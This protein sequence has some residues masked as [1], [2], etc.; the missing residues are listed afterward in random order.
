MENLIRYKLSAGEASHMCRDVSDEEIKRAMFLI[1]DN[2]APG[3]Y[4]FSSLFFK[5]SW[6]IIGKDVCLVVKEF[7]NTEKILREI[8]STLIALVPKIQTPLKVFD[9]RPITCCNVLYKCISK[10]IF[11]RLKGCLDKLVSKNQSAFVPRRHIQDNIM[12]DHE[13]FK[14]YDRKVGPK[15]IALK[16]DIQKAY[17]TGGRGLRQGDP[18]SPY[19]FTLV[20]EIL[21]QMIRQKIEQC[22]E[23]KYH[24]GCKRLKITNVCFADDLLLFCHADKT[25]VEKLPIRYLGVLLTSKRIGIKECKSLLDKVECRINNWK[26]RCLSYAGRLLLVALVLESIHVYWASVFLLP[27]GVIKDI[28]KLLKG[29][30]WNH[31]D[32]SKG[33]AKVAW[34]NVC[35]AKQK[36]GMGLKDLYVWNKAMIVKHLWH[37]ASDKES[38]WEKWVNTGKL[39]GKSIWEID[40][41]KDDSWCWKNLLRIRKEVRKYI[42]T[43]VGNGLTTS[44]CWPEEWTEEFPILLEIQNTLLNDDKTDVRVWKNGGGKRGLPTVAVGQ[45]GDAF[46]VGPFCWASIKE[47]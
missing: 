44:L 20:M 1:D 10:I 43:K 15:K 18:M 16:V 4:G 41:E 29:F 5:K 33:R 6:S 7:F 45:L 3:P 46:F 36:E 13:M 26:N 32:G 8:N 14:G 21:T 17:D 9:F 37:I 31:A 22:S 35:N 34:K 42:I 2:K 23:F 24:Y 39:K 47:M 40:E 12:L 28:N 30:L 25:S 11:E 19:L 27:H 38:L